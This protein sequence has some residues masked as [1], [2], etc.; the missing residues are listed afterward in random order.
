M[1]N[2]GGFVDEKALEAPMNADPTPMAA[3]EI[4]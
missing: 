3:D 1:R 2:G 4:V